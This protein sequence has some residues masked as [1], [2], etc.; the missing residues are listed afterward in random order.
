MKKVKVIM[1]K[2]KD[3]FRVEADGKNIPNVKGVEIRYNSGN[4]PEVT[5]TMEVEEV[6]TQALEPKLINKEN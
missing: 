6:E 1:A 5:L 2:D 3:R 4:K